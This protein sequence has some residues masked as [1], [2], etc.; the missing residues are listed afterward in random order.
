M[1]EK[2]GGNRAIDELIAEIADS[3]DRVR[4][5]L[6]GLH[7]ELDFPAKL[8]RSF[9][10]QTVSWITAAAAVGALIIL[11]PLR[12]K[13]IYV[14]KKSGSKA[15]NRLLETGFLL[16]ALKIAAGLARPV[17]VELVKNRLFDFA[18][19]SRP[20]RKRERV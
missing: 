16:G 10:E 20:P 15:R 7:Y 6:R 18:G 12:R 1:A 3:R 2:S 4:R 5:N 17:V 19:Q 14:D 9:R 8:R 11:L 13:K